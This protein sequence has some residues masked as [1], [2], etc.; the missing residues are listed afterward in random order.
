MQIALYR[1]MQN[2]QDCAVQPTS[3]STPNGLVGNF[4]KLPVVNWRDALGMP[5]D[6]IKARGL[7]ML[8]F[9]NLLMWLGFFVVVP[10][11]SLHFVDNLGWGA[12]VV[13]AALG[14]RTIMQQGFALVSGL[15]ADRFDARILIYLGLVIRS[16]GFAALAL[17]QDP[18][19]LFWAMF[20]SG[21]GGGF[22][23]APKNAAIAA[24]TEVEKRPKVYAVLGVIGNLGMAVGSLLGTALLQSGFALVALVAAALYLLTLVGNWLALPPLKISSGEG[25]PLVGLGEV[26][27]DTRFLQFTVLLSGMFLMW[28][29]FSLGLTLVAVRLSGTQA[30]VSWVFLVNTVVAILLQ[31]PLTQWANR[32]LGSMQALALGTAVMA[33]S[34]C[35]VAFAPN[36]VVLLF[37]VAAFSIGSSLQSA[38]QQVLVAQLAKEHVRGAYFGFSALAFAVGG[39][40]G[41]FAGGLL[42]DLGK[43][44]GLPSLSWLI[45]AA[46]GFVTAIAMWRFGRVLESL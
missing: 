12:A 32:F 31:Y 29:Q 26:L 15:L 38:P 20:L 42:L 9:S 33:L 45:L 18:T 30:A 34:L 1:N 39:G 10:I 36:I 11:V 19:G 22:F 21:V 13:G 28:S 35:G 14:I 24:L 8:M 17:V 27:R 40:I 7:L 44:F 2:W 41:N 3:S 16:L 37:C 23:E 6:P 46:C 4:V 25:K 43:S 5:T